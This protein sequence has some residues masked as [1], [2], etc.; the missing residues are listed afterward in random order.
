MPCTAVRLVSPRPDADECTSDRGHRN[1][2]VP[3]RHASDGTARLVVVRQPDGTRLGLAFTTPDALRTVLGE[4]QQHLLM[5][6]QALRALLAAIDVE[7]I[8]V[9]P[10]GLAR[11]SSPTDRAHSR[12][13]WVDPRRQVM[14]VKVP[15]G[16]RTPARAG[17]TLV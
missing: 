2:V 16:C 9:D 6:E 8:H 5:A 11:T 14:G 12:D 10:D 15:Y 7:R 3:V 1:L 4:D 17:I 13:D